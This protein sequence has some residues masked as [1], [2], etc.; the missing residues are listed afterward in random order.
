MQEYE[1]G[2]VI[3]P[4]LAEDGVQSIVEK[5]KNAIVDQGGVVNAVDFWGK[6][7][8]AYPIEKQR[9]GYYVFLRFAISPKNVAEVS[10]VARYTEDILRHIL[11]KEEKARSEEKP[12][13][14]K[15]AE[16]QALMSGKETNV[17]TQSE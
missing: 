17:P 16:A 5:L 4:T 12:Q 14:P 15:E 11:V 13:T 6:R 8:L 3:R 7:K 2:V 9:E 1:L 10:R